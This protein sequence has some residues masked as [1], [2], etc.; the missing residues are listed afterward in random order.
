MKALQGKLAQV[1]LTSGVLLVGNCAPA[2]PGY[3]R[4]EVDVRR[5]DLRLYWKD[6]ANRPLR[7]LHRLRTWLAGHGRQVVFAMNAGMFKPDFSPLGL[8]IQDGKLVAP[9]N[10]ASGAGNFYLKPNGVFYTT[11]SHQARICSSP[12]F[13]YS[14]QV[15]YA[16]QSGPLLVLDGQ[17]HPAFT[18]GSRNR[19]I[20]NGVGIL[21]N[22]HA[23]FVLSKQ[24]V[25]LY[26]FADYFRRQGCRNA[27][28]LDG[29]VSRAYVPA[30]QWEQTDGDFG[31]MIGVT[32][33]GAE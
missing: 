13:R 24:K 19:Q 12:R 26:E 4:Y 3:V 16:T 2:D 28:Y 6:D 29:F 21:P 9:L 18:A 10:T 5:Q 1:L 11:F 14:S 8:F 15:Q 33:P 27:L 20:R 23:L 25:S 30:Q 31:V 32:E 22:G 7:S 17:I